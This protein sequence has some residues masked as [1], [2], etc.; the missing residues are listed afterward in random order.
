M[1]AHL[2]LRPGELP[3]RRPVEPRFYVGESRLHAATASDLLPAPRHENSCSSLCTNRG[4]PLECWL[5]CK[6]PESAQ[7]SRGV[8]VFGMRTDA[9]NP[10]IALAERGRLVG[11]QADISV[12]CEKSKY[13]AAAIDN[14]FRPS[15]LE[16]LPGTNRG[17]LA[18]DCRVKI[19]GAGTRSGAF[20]SE[21]KS[22]TSRVVDRSG[23]GY[24]GTGVIVAIS[25]LRP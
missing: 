6:W 22:R 12:W 4:A 19:G 9:V 13:F 1:V 3:G 17:G 25:T 14:V 10:A 24:S 7:L 23:R 8:P 20:V 18:D 11:R 21:S 2:Q 16:R 5:R 15:M